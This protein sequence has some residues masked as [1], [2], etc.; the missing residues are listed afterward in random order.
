MR[1]KTYKCNQ[2]CP[3]EATLELIG[4]KWKGVILYHLLER[5]YRFGELKRVMPGVTQRMLTKQLREL[6]S[7]GIINRKVYAQVPPKV[8]YSVTEVGESLR[9]IIMTMCKWGKN[10]FDL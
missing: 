1:H 8:E 9:D 10:H 2:G 6:E 5:T 7:D 4:G 3:V